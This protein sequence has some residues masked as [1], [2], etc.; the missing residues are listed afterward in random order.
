MTLE[1]LKNIAPKL[2]ELQQLKS[3]FSFPKD[4]FGTVED[5]IFSK[6]LEDTL[7]K[8]TPFRTPKNYFSTIE[9][10]VLESLKSEEKENVYATPKGYFDSVE[11][12]VFERLQTETKVIDFKTRFIKKFLPIVAAASL[13]L[14]ITL[15]LLNNTTEQKDLFASLETSEIEN[16]IENGDFE[17]NSYQIAAV[18]EDTNIEDIELEQEYNDDHLMEYL[19]DIDLE[20]LILTN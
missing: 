2:H 13:L 10:R 20:S 19:D 8:K 18:Y 1:G 17:M 14:F 4:Y 11:D 7:D 16:W 15:Q 6:L 5:A 3:G 9:D 12:K